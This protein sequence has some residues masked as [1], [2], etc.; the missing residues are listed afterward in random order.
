MR[1]FDKVYEIPAL[2]VTDNELKRALDITW[3]NTWRRLGVRSRLCDRRCFQQVGDLDK[4]FAST[5]VLSVLKLLLLVSMQW[6]M[7]VG[8]GIFC[9]DFTTAFLHA[10]LN[11]DEPPPPSSCAG[12]ERNPGKNNLWRL[13]T[14]AYTDCGTLQEIGGATSPLK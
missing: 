5:L 10:F 12:E 4:L 13:R 14:V 9:F 1:Y 11:P 6:G 7:S 2:L 8:L 3:V